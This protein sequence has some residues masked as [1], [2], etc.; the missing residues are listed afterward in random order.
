MAKKMPVGALLGTVAGGALGSFGGPAGAMIGAGIGGSL[1]G[2]FDGDGETSQVPL[3]TPEQRHARAALVNFMNTGRFGDFKAGEEQNLGYGDFGITGIEQTGQSKLQELLRGGIPSQYAMG[4]E[5]LQ[6]FLKPD[7]NQIATQFAPYNDLMDRSLMESNRSLKRGAGFAGNLYS[8]DTIRGLGDIQARG[9]ETKSAE[10]A[11][12]TNQQL[13]RKL[14]AVPL[15]YQSAQAQQGAKLEQIAASQSYGAL[16]RQLNNAGIQ[17]RDAEILR[18][19]SEL[20]LPI[21]AAMSVAGTGA[22]FGVPSVAN[23]SPY[24]DLLGM[25]GQIGGAYAG[26]AY[27]GPKGQTPPPPTGLRASAQPNYGSGGAPYNVYGSKLNP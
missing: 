1:G 16:T 8:T 11:R 12:L 20:Q 27:Q 17:A 15:A 4:D 19:R 5:A 25:I 6:S 22:Q 13:D 23:A 26:G 9:N 24:A 18:R 7:P 21:Q 14:Q 3:E 2:S 10:L